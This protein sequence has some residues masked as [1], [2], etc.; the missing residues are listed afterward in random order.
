[1]H[2]ESVA[3]TQAFRLFVMTSPHRKE[4]TIRTIVPY[5]TDA[6]PGTSHNSVGS[7]SRRLGQCPI[8]DADPVLIC[9]WLKG[10]PIDINGVQLQLVDSI[11]GGWDPWCQARSI[12]HTGVC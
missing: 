2:I 1:M 5:A 7:K 6:V 8:Q 9:S 10:I 12:G 3:T 11:V 4:Q